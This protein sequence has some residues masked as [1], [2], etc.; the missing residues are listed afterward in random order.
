MPP[1]TAA[2][3]S[4]STP[5]SSLTA[6]SSVPTLAEQ[7]LVGRDDRL[8]VPQRSGDQLASR[9]DAADHLDDQIDGRV[10]NDRVSVAGQHT[11]GEVDI[12]LAAEVAHWRT[13]PI[14]RRTP[15][16]ASMVACWAIT[17]L[18]KAEPTLPHPSTPITHELCHGRKAT[19]GDVSPEKPFARGQHRRR[20]SLRRLS[21]DATEPLPTSSAAITRPPVIRHRCFGS[22]VRSRC[23]RHGLG[24]ATHAPARRP[25]AGGRDRIGSGVDAR[26]M[27]HTVVVGDS[28]SAHPRRMPAHRT[29]RRADAGIAAVELHRHDRDPSA[30]PST[31]TTWEEPGREVDDRGDERVWIGDDKL[32]CGDRWPGW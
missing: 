8:A 1:A 24:R 21:S 5:A 26:L 30:R 6:N 15:V 4:R 32:C 11:V 9:L 17:R 16:R 19:G 3:N 22:C 10:G 12:A 20:S 25:G 13:A 29:N 27:L 14:S 28:R 18:T 7:L 2:S 23:V 31:V